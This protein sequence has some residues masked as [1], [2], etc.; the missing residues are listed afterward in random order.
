MVT[1][2]N[3][4]SLDDFTLK[5]TLGAENCWELEEEKKYCNGPLSPGEKYGMMIRVF[6]DSGFRD[7]KPVFIE[8]DTGPMKLL[9]KKEIIYGSITGAVTVVLIISALIGYV[10]VRKSKKKITMKEKEAAEADENLLSFTSYCVIDK[11][12]QPRKSY[13]DL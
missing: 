7:T 11:N 5:F 13:D 6:T 4:N 12:P 9:S 10:C 2:S 3:E 8:I 1:H